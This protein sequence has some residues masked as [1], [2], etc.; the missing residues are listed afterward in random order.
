[1]M[2]PGEKFYQLCKKLE[3]GNWIWSFDTKIPKSELIFSIDEIHKLNELKIIFNGQNGGLVLGNSHDEGGI[4]LLR[5]DVEKNIVIYSGEM[6]GFEYLSSPLKSEQHLNDLSHINNL[7]TEI[8]INKE[9]SIPKN[10]NIIDTSNIEI[11]A[12][13]L[14][15]YKHFIIKKSSTFNY[16]DKILEI[17]KKY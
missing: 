2:I 9:I 5:L 16:F 15:E 1:M 8:D 12:I 17:E 10:C 7:K 13:L 14:S 3:I 4:H 11:P 6:E